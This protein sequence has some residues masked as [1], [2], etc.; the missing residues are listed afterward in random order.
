PEGFR[1]TDLGVLMQDCFS[2]MEAQSLS[3]ARKQPSA[4]DWSLLI[5]NGMWFQDL[6]NYDIEAGEISSVPV[7]TELGEISF[8]AYNSSNWRK[9]VEHVNRTASL[10]EWIRAHGRHQIYANG[11]QVPLGTTAPNRTNASDPGVAIESTPGERALV[12]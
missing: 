12:K 3:Q 2:R 4:G 1:A 5:V 6:F 7:A 11:K 9:S 10:S 8:A